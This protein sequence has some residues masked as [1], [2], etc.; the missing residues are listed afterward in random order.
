MILGG[1][2]VTKIKIDFFEELISTHNTGLIV[3]NGFSMNFDSCF[4]NIYACLKEGSYALSKNGVFSISPGAKP[5]TKA[6]IKENY[7]NV[8]RYV[9]TL[10][11]K[12]LEEIF[13]DAVAFAGFITT[14][15]TIWD[16]LNQNKHLNRLK[17]GPDMLEITENIYRIG[18]TKG[19]QFVNIENWPILIWLFH[20]IEDLAEFKN[21]NQQNNR[22]IT[23]LKIGGRKSIS[24]PNSAGDVIVKTRFN[25]FAIYYRLLMLTIIFGNGKA[26]DLKKTEYAEKVNRNSL[27]CW[28]QEFKELFSLNYDLL[29][30]QIAHR[31]VTYLHGHFRNNAAGFSYFQSYSMRYGDKQYY[32]NDIILGDYAT[33]KVLDQ[34]IHS[35]AM[36][37]IAFEQPRVDPL[38]ELTLK[39]N[40]SNINHIVFF[41]MHP[42][43]DYHILSGIYHN[44]LITKQDNPMIT[45]CYFNEQEIEDFTNTFYKVTDSIYRNKNII[46]LHFVDSKEVI[47]RYFV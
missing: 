3:G 24:P 12:Q 29:L 16:F 31:P 6:T 5:H 13:K 19:F 28:L 42:E 18:S 11:Q 40:D 15:S 43:N 9:R 1:Y 41:G 27:T 10:N 22:F 44:F 20:L 26:V 23:L 38:K 37:D 45:Y 21:Y 32:T 30:E 4:S 17:V 33:T 36:R 47:N 2:I 7:N 35:L 14:N 39:M 25:G 46:P 8:L 34:F